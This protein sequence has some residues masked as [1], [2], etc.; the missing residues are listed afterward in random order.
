MFKGS[1]MLG[2]DLP[3][4]AHDMMLRFMNVDFGKITTGTAGRISSSLGDTPKA[5]PLPGG[6]TLSEL[7]LNAKWQGTASRFIS[8]N[9]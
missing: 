4:V 1:H 9:D 2:W 6:G 8:R 7:E 3:H 5:T